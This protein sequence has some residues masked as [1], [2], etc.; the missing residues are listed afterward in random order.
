MKARLVKYGENVDLLCSD[1]TIIHTQ[2]SLRRKFFL[3]F[4][5]TE[6]FTGTEK[7][8][9]KF[10]DMTDY[11]GE[12]LAYVSDDKKLV[13]VDPAM[14]R[15]ALKTEDS[16]AGFRGM[17]TT[18]EYAQKH[19]KSKEMIKAFCNDGRI[20]GAKKVGRQWFIPEDA[21]YPIEEKSQKPT[22]GRTK[23]K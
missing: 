12:T 11:P 8:A 21:P 5:E 4:D 7:W 15:E 10:L 19:N 23:R 9:G 3:H 22:A 20:I 6:I 16:T 14:L 17:L 13:V 1:G 18:I 2:N